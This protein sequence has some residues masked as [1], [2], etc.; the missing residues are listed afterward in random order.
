MKPGKKA[1]IEVQGTAIG[2]L[3]QPGGDY[4]SLTDMVRN[5]DGGGALIE[6]WLK[7]KD[8]VLFLG[9]WERINNPVLIPS[10]SRELEMRPAAIVFSCPPKQW[11]EKTGAKGSP[12]APG[13][14]AAPMPTRTSPSNSAPG[15]V[16]NSSSISSG[17]S[18][19]SRTTK[20]TASRSLG[21]SSAPSPR[22]TTASTPTP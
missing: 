5:F 7:N 15:S 8:T 17:N 21:T 22:S 14:T 20:T 6:Q 13:V 10:N 9:V 19:G 16:R 18:N 4:I 3:S 11:I 12:R 1:T 2:I